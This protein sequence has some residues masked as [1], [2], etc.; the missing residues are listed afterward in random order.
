MNQLT[1]TILIAA[2]LPVVCAAIAKWGAQGYD[3]NHPRSWMSAQSGFR[4]RAD[5]AQ[6]NSLE[7]FPPFAVALILAWV[8]GLPES[9]LAPWAWA[10][11]A[12][13]VAYIALYVT[14]RAT[15]RSA[16]WI[17]GLIVVLRLFAF[18]I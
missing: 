12:C 7:A 11:I 6:Q 17:L 9:L 14:D 8:Q 10:F 1:L 13:R 2:L 16:V 4:A 15:W 18:S 3:N 5:A